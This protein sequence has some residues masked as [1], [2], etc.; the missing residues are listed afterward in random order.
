MNRAI[1]DIGTNTAHILIAKV[2][3]QKIER[4]LHKERHYTFLGEDG[5]DHISQTAVERLLSALQ[6]FEESINEHGCE[7]VRVLATEGLRS[8][9]N[10]PDI[11]GMISDRY[12]WP[13]HIISGEKEARYIYQGAN[14]S[15]DLSLGSSLIMDIGGG[16]V[17]FIYVRD[18]KVIF[19]KS[20]PIGI[21]RLYEG[22][23]FSDPISDR[24]VAAIHLHLES[25][26]SEMWAA[27]S[28]NSLPKL[29]GCA[30]TFEIFLSKEDVENINTSAKRVSVDKV[31][32]LWQEVRT[33]NINQRMLVEDLPKER[34]KYIVVAVLLV[35]YVIDRLMLNDFTVS[36]FALKEGGII[37]SRLFLD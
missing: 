27:V 1:I 17:E 20:F 7:Q 11:Q 24:E 5:L 19:Q 16:S 18:A 32:S 37:D 21:S 25:T 31:D 12:G 14:L 33:K 22:Y 8:A 15:T 23:H 3:D 26:L 36:K 28:L 29:I 6:K 9:A 34:V 4:L 35:K 10:G 13:I 2:V 30:G